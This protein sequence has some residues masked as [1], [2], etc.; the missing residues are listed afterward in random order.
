MHDQSFVTCF[1]YAHNL[2]GIATGL[3]T[4]LI[5]GLFHP[6]VIKAEYHLG[7]KSWWIFL[8]MGILS[9]LSAVGIKDTLCSC[10]L[11][12]IAFSSFWSIREV[13]E[14]RERVRKGWFPENKKRKKT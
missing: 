9:A 12:I 1:L 3:I 8:F 4:F 2:L 5:I 10:T 6:L 7:V 11:S 14:Q 13:F